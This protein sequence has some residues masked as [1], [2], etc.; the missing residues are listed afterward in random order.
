MTDA[1]VPTALSESDCL[2][3]VAKKSEYTAI[4]SDVFIKECRP[5]GIDRWAGAMKACKEQGYH[6]PTEQQLADMA[7]A[8]YTGMQASATDSLGTWKYGTNNATI[9]SAL[10]NN[11]LPSALSGLGSSWYDLWSGPEI[12]SPYAYHRYFNSTRSYR[13]ANYRYRSDFRAVCVGD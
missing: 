9:G 13:D 11:E 6:L 1:F 3:E 10:P 2:A 5:G 12:S 8:L 4:N 7:N